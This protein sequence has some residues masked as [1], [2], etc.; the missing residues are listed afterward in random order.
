MI[1]QS[2]TQF[3]KENNY[4]S[5]FDILE[6]GML[7]SS[8]Y[9]SKRTKDVAMEAH[10]NK[11]K[12]HEEAIGIFCELIINDEIT[13]TNNKYIKSELLEFKR[14]EHNKPLEIKIMVNERQIE[15][16]NSLGKMSHLE[17]GK[18]KKSYQRSVDFSLH[19]IAECKSKLIKE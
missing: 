16:I 12:L 8:G 4:P 3:C 19:K 14:K 11:L 9:M 10:L 15:Y 1:H 17:N 18:L 2:L 13:D 7:G 6:H 5:E